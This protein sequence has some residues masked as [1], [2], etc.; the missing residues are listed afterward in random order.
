MRRLLPMF[1]V[2]AVF[3]PIFAALSVLL[4]PSA[5]AAPGWQRDTTWTWGYDPPI[6]LTLAGFR[7]YQDG[8]PVCEYSLPEARTASCKITLVKKTTAFTLTAFFS[9]GQ[10]SPHSD[11]YILVDWGPKPHLI[12]VRPR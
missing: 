6:D 3:L 1:T 8:N 10:E 5:A 4:P 7:M 2:L 12:E 9:D 11:P